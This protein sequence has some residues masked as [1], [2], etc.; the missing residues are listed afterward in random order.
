VDESDVSHLCDRHGLF[1]NRDW[2]RKHTREDAQFET[3]G[4]YEDLLKSGYSMHYYFVAT[5][6]ASDQG[7]STLTNSGE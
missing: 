4:S 6:V 1:R 2:V 7:C 3:L 5:G